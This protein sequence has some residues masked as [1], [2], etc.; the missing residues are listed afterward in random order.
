MN[1][2][3]ADDNASQLACEHCQPDTALCLLALMG[4]LLFCLRSDVLSSAGLAMLASC[5]GDP[6]SPAVAAAW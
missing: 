6:H 1:V 2:N 4:D 3:A 5:L